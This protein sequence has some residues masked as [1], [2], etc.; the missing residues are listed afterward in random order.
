MKRNYFRDTEDSLI[1]ALRKVFETEKSINHHLQ[2]LIK[3]TNNIDLDEDEV[4]NLLIPQENKQGWSFTE[5]QKQGIKEIIKHNVVIIRGYGGTGKSS[6]VA[7][8]LSCL[9]EFY[10][11]KQCALSG[12]ASVNLRDI[13]G[14]DGSTIHT[15]LGYIPK[16]GFK[17][18]EEN[19]LQ[20]NMVILDEAS[21]P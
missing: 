11:F 1:I 10:S 7:G 4:D 19:P 3:G 20:T 9:D 17:H 16:Q 18:N 2:R 21:M 5:R 12:K 13:T 8:V 6:T 15:L 14:Q